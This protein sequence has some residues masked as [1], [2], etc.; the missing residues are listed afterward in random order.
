MIPRQPHPLTRW[1]S[2]PLLITL[3]VLALAAGF[4]S[5]LPFLVGN[6]RPWNTL[7]LLLTAV[8]LESIYT[9][10]WLR[11][12]SRLTLN[13][14]VYRIS[15]L[16]VIFLG[17]RLFT[18]L[19]SGNW[20][21]TD[22]LPDAL[23]SP[24]QLFQDGFFIVAMGMTLAVWFRA[25]KITAL[26][27]NLAI[28]PAEADYFSRPSTERKTAN[29]PIVFSREPAVRDFFSQWIGGGILLILL[30]AGIIIGRVNTGDGRTLPAHLLIALLTYFFT[31]FFLF[32]WGRL[33]LLN[34]RWFLSGAVVAAGMNRMWWRQTWRIILAMALIAAFLPLG[35]TFAIGR[36]L[37]LLAAGIVWLA[38]AFFTLLIAILSLLALPFAGLPDAAPEPLPTLGPL[39]T[40]APPPTAVL[41]SD[42]LGMIASSLFWAIALVMGIAAISF[43]LRD[44]GFRLALNR[45]QVRMWWQ[46]FVMWL[47]AVWRHNIK[48]PRLRPFWPEK[49]S[50]PAI[51]KVASDRWRFIRLSALSPRDQIRYFYLSIARRAGKKGARRPDN[52]TPLEYAQHLVEKWPD[53]NEAINGLTEKFLEAQYTP[54]P[55]PSAE[56]S[57]IKKHWRWLRDKIRR[58]ADDTSVP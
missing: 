30:T 58:T 48:T 36:V 57:P 33:A 39:P 55:I 51:G 56:I 46:E 22:L 5:L 11:H 16:V 13:H 8:S 24:S 14:L 20:P 37:S 1:L 26:F 19:A 4:L 42:T 12:P 50:I 2:L 43:F 44:R 47:T 28:H 21:T 27:L 52:A 32:S 3:H 41:P 18:W 45:M 6:D 54:R 38:T 34:A 53:A 15:E 25:Q 17:A 23:R 31:G 10:Q 9:T 40:P 35:S 29:K 49:V 7:L